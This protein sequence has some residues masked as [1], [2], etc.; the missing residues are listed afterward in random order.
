MS[1]TRADDKILGFEYQFYYYLLEMLKLNA[2]EKVGF[3]V[4]DDVHIEDNKTLSL[5]QLKH[6]RQTNQ[7]GNPKNLTTS[8]IDLWKTLSNWVDV[9]NLEVD[10]SNFITNT[11]FVFITNKAESEK[12]LFLNALKD[13]KDNQDIVSFR[14]KIS[15]YINSLEADNTNKDYIENLITLENLLL[16]TFVLKIEFIFDLNDIIGVV[17]QEIQFGRSIKIG[18]V[19][20]VFHELTGLY[21]EKFFEIVKDKKDFEITRDKFYTDTLMIFQNAKSERLPF[22]TNIEKK[23]NESI[24]NHTFAKQLLDIGFDKEK[25]F[26][27]DYYKLAIETNLNTFLQDGE[28]SE[29]DKNLLDTNSITSWDEEFQDIYLEDTNRNDLNAKKLYLNVLKK[30]LDLA[31]QKIEWKEAT[32]GQFIKMSDISK[33]GWKYTWKEEYSDEI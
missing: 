21:K 30:D 14:N 11:N 27:A 32:K 33:I 29:N 5:I 12:H 9:I 7:Y 18:R 17:K 31:G 16:K 28:I 10:K 25:V 19:S 2:D 15:D 26:D 3:E 6:T 24:L 13:L 1:S 22:V 23:N 20:K 4:K 8:D